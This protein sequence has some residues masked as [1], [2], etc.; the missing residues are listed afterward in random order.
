MIERYA[1]PEISEIWSDKNRFRIWLDIEILAV[2]ALVKQGVIPAPALNVIKEKADFDVE[3]ILEIEEEVK[4]DVI[5]F[6]TN[7]AE[8][9]GDEARYIHYGMTSS[10]VLDTALAI[11][12]VQAAGLIKEQL[13][14]LIDI[15]KKR[16]LETK[17]MFMVGRSHGVHA[18]PITFG[19]KMALWYDELKR[20]MGRLE[21]AIETVRV[22]QISGAVGT[23]DHLSPE[24]QDYVCEKLGLKSSNISSQILQRDRHAHYAST[25]ALIGGTL[26]KIAVEI[27]HLQRTEVLEATEHFSKGQKGSSAMPHKKNPIVSER[28]SGMVRLLRGNALAAM[29]NMALWHERD[30]S[31]SS[32]ERVILPDSTMTLYYMLKK[33]TTLLRDLDLY[34]ENMQN[35][36]DL[37]HGLVYSQ[38]VLLAL[39]Q[40]GISR[41]EAYRL[42][43][44]NAMKVWDDQI[45]FKEA[46]K[47]DETI[48]NS[49]TGEDLDNLFNIKNRLKNIDTIFKKVGLIK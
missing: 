36:M 45:S 23:F 49:M 46:L 43:Q 10:D 9:V 19:L 32:V 42:V 5:A 33:T 25:M 2:E 13:T 39:T 15:V 48:G 22:G 41:E 20:Q 24:I 35:N 6:L 17:D 28:I 16:A 38:A 3:R 1:L 29:E 21:E 34:P 4:H 44:R 11:Q 37:T 7:V 27:R 26:E 30:I 14:E 12:M 18:E 31:H 8:Y 40:K 47:K